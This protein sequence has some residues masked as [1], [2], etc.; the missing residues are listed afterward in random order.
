MSD[1]TAE[2]H[3]ILHE[4]DQLT[5]ELSARLSGKKSLTNGEVV[6]VSRGT[7]ERV[8][9]ILSR[10]GRAAITKVLLQEKIGHGIKM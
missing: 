6:W 5:G 2:S 4:I 9:E 1:I 7:L 8:L 10:E 3:K